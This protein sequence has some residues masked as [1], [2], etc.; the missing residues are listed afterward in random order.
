MQHRYIPKKHKEVILERQHDRCANKPGAN[1]YRLGD[2]PCVLWES[3]RNGVFTDAGYE[4]DH[5]V[6]FSL[7]HNNS[8]DNLQALCHGCHA[9]RTKDFQHELGMA[10]KKGIIRDYVAENNQSIV[11]TNDTD[12]DNQEDDM[13]DYCP[14]CGIGFK[15]K[16]DA[17]KH[18]KKIYP[19][20]GV[21]HGNVGKKH[22]DRVRKATKKKPIYER[23][24]DGHIICRVCSI[25]KIKTFPCVGNYNR[26]IKS[27]RHQN[28]V[29]LRKNSIDI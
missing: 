21:V 3:T 13:Y 8:I 28:N 20:I 29:T 15:T 6:E 26:H 14:K 18:A 9:Y 4:I 1:L 22:S 23:N 5:I 11:P 16:N 19:C 7:T 2:F 17:L 12:K 25:N 10:R 27:T 24:D